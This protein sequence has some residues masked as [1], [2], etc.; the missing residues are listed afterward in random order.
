MRP[1]SKL[2]YGPRYCIEKCTMVV[3]R[4]YYYIYNTIPIQ[5]FTFSIKMDGLNG[6]IVVVLIVVGSSYQ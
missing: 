4:I 3:I 1:W 6:K 5:Y 2:I